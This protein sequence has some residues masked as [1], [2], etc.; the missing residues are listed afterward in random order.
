MFGI[1]QSLLPAVIYIVTL[2]AVVVIAYCIP[3][4]VSQIRSEL[5]KTNERLDRML[6]QLARLTPRGEVAAGTAGS[7]KLMKVCLSCH[8]PNPTD[9]KICSTCKRVI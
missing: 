4:S 3:R 5:V 2:L 7:R 9:A 8:T 1:D 6:A